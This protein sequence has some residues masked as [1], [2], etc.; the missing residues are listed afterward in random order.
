MNDWAK[1]PQRHPWSR[2]SGKAGN[3]RMGTM[4]QKLLKSH[5]HFLGVAWA[6]P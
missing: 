2:E 4:D 6:L 1:G 5:G 3:L